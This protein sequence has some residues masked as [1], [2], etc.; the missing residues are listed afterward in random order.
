M[1]PLCYLNLELKKIKPIP[2]KLKGINKYTEKENGHKH[3][4][5]YSECPDAD[6]STVCTWRAKLKAAE[7][8]RAHRVIRRVQRVHAIFRPQRHLSPL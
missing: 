2:T 6:E 5:F 4:G 3:R 8:N 1:P 7:D